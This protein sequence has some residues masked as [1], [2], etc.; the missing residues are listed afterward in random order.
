MTMT[1]LAAA[2]GA[3]A[4]ADMAARKI[5]ETIESGGALHGIDLSEDGR[6]LYVVALGEEAV[7]AV[8]LATVA[9]RSP[10]LTSPCHLAA[11]D[12]RGELHVTQSDGPTRTVIDPSLALKGEIALEGRG[13]Q[14]VDA[15]GSRRRP[16]MGGRGL[17][18]AEGLAGRAPRRPRLRRSPASRRV[19]GEP[20]PAGTSAHAAAGSE[21]RFGA[22]S[23]RARQTGGW[24]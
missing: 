21:R 13:R 2:D 18:S 12:E 6:G 17:S 11:L 16:R 4:G 10:P 9:R 24:S 7:V 19:R 20:K 5:L 1:M 15:P 8:D 23:R 14:I 22:R 3:A